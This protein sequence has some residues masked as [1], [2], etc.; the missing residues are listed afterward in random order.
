MIFVTVGTN[1]APFDRLLRAVESLEPGD[2][3]AQC[4]SSALRPK[5][6][7]CVDFLPFEQLVAYVQSA[8]AV[9]THAG[10]GSIAVALANGKRPV[11]VPRLQRY[12]EAIDDHQVSLG[13]R[14]QRSGLVTLVEDPARLRDLQFDAEP[15]PQVG[16]VSSALAE[17]LSRYLHE[18]VFAE[19]HPFSKSRYPAT[20]SGEEGRGGVSGRGCI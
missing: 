4:G 16:N 18:L 1:E 14:L 5:N 10:V 2:L 9:V 11:V 3:V 13:R 17:D 15:P 20:V 12:G 6:A 19:R 8:S 7:T